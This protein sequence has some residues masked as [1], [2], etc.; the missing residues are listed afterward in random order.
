MDVQGTKSKEQKTRKKNKN[1]F[2]KCI[3]SAKIRKNND[4]RRIFS[5]KILETA[6]KSVTFACR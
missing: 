5:L 3:F 1:R 6:R 4:I 2:I